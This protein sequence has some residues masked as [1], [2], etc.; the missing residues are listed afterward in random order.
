MKRVLEYAAR[1]P[2]TEL[3]SVLSKEWAEDCWMDA[4]NSEERPFLWKG[5]HG[6]WI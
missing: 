6:T 5:A 2:F 1:S 4:R 3:I